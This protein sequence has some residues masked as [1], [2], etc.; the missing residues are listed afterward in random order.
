MSLREVERAAGAPWQPPLTG[1]FDRLV[2]HSEL[3]ENNPLGDPARRPLYVYRPPDAADQRLPS[4]YM[5][6]GFGGRLE[7]WLT[8]NPT[9]PNVIERLDAMFADGGCPP[10]VIVFVDAWTSRGGSQFLNSA[11]TGRYLDYLCDEVIPFVD[12][13]YRTLPERR[14]RGV[15][16]RSSGGYGAMVVSMLR[17]DLFGALASQAGDLAFECCYRPLFPTAARA[18]RDHFDSSWDLFR[19]RVGWSEWREHPLLFATYGTACAYTPDPTRPGEAL[20]P[21]EP[22]T[23][24]LIDDVW[25]RWLELDPLRLAAAHADTLASMRRIY[26]DAGRRDEF[27]LDLGATAFSRE[28]DRL[29][30]EHTLELFDGDHGG[31]TDRIPGAVRELVLALYDRG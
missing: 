15:A 23:G 30:I 4:V 2:V 3:L 28:L 29:G 12:S 8:P 27:F 19:Q 11:G 21:F 22:D 1:A 31:V 16:G 6:Q 26:L 20:L 9:G 25:G 13:Q 24:A 17:P 14:H 5:L 10:A 18:L 7:D